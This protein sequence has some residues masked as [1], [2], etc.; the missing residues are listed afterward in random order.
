MDCWPGPQV[1]TP[2]DGPVLSWVEKMMRYPSMALAALCIAGPVLAQ[3]QTLRPGDRLSERVAGFSW[4]SPA[5]ASLG[6]IGNRRVYLTGL[7]TERLVAAAG[8][9]AF[10]YTMELVP[11]AIVERTVGNTENC[12]RNPEWW[13]FT[14][15][16]DRSARVSVGAGGS[17]MGFK[18]YLNRGGLNRVYAAGGVGGLIFSSEVPVEKSRRAN[19]TFEYGGGVEVP[20]K[21]GASVTLGYRFHHIS[22]GGT[23]KLNPGL[24]A[25][26]FY[27]GMVSR[28]RRVE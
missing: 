26:V 5:A 4:Y 9:L 22:N 10:A 12:V 2:G 28:Q 13:T 14:C 8:P 7:R 20:R 6:Q 3:S 23:R 1:L 17:P 11:L 27:V 21:G 15:R 18:L 24:D 16:Y 19:F 25:N